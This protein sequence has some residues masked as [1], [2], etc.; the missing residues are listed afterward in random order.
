M[1]EEGIWIHYSR[2]RPHWYQLAQ[3]E[4][5]DLTAKWSGVRT[6]SIAAGGVALGRYHIRGQHD[7]ETVEIWQFPSPEAVFDHWARLTS[8]HYNEWYAFA[9]NIGLKTND[10]REAQ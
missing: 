3:K 8:S 9:N 5:D 2:P 10:A 6:V 1:T 4:R 7:F